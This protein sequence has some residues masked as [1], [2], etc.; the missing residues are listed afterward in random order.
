MSDFQ[1]GRPDFSDRDSLLK[2]LE[3]QPKE[4]GVVIAA[5]A[6]L[7]VL[8]L[9]AVDFDRTKDGGRPFAPLSFAV[10]WATAL[11]H[12]VG[13]YPTRANELHP[14]TSVAA[15]EVSGTEGA[16][17]ESATVTSVTASAASAATAAATV[18]SAAFATPATASYAASHAAYAAANADI[19]DVASVAHVWGALSADVRAIG[20]GRTA[21]QLAGDPL[22]LESAP[23][24]ADDS[25]TE[26]QAAL[27]EPQWKPWRDWYQR[28][29]DGRELSEELELLFATLPVDPREKDPAEQNALLAREIEWLT[30]PEIPPQGPGPHV[31]IDI[32][33]GTIVPAK[34]ESL[35]REGNNVAR[36][37][38]HHPQI[39]KLAGDLVNAISAN[40]QPELY[41]SASSYFDNVNRDLSDIDFDQLWGE[42]VFLEEVAAAA[43]RGVNDMKREPLSDIALGTLNALLKVHGPFVLSSRAGLENLAL[44]KTFEQRPEEQREEERSAREFVKEFKNYPDVV[45]AETTAIFAHFIEQPDSTSHPERSAAFKAGMSRNLVI[46]LVAGAALG[47]I[48]GSAGALISTTAGAATGMAFLP[49]IEG[50]KKSKPF[51]EV[52]RIVTQGMNNLSEAE[53]HALW[54]RLNRI[55][56]DR[57]KQFIF[58]NEARLLRLVGDRANGRWLH[59]YIEWLKRQD[60]Q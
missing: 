53:I 37:R 13:K 56:F 7:R 41:A 42:G 59:E 39:R 18:S 52:S 36:L 9:I 25:W 55:P 21:G 22:W 54:K 34:P 48:I 4:V 60:R 43:A 23:K 12:V 19:D 49:V 2:W 6:A 35:D 46:N 29:L 51:L 31:E 47:G 45:G 1:R 50:W 26:F 16:A 32:E 57:Y 14:A 17:A 28:R 58:A 27:S 38:A 5:R 40:E 8:P 15:A 30:P 44:A 10:F 11:A 20:S 3:T 24:W 33:S